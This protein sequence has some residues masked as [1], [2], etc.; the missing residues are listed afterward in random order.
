MTSAGR[1]QPPTPAKRDPWL[2]MADFLAKEVDALKSD[3]NFAAEVRSAAH[4]LAVPLPAAVV[5]DRICSAV[6]RRCTE[7]VASGDFR[8]AAALLAGH[9]FAI[10]QW[11]RLKN[12]RCG[13]PAATPDD[14]PVTVPG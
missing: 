13:G 12:R 8:Q 1:E 9:R 11:S 4:R 5:T 6:A 2:A 3:P 10:V 7:L 14:N